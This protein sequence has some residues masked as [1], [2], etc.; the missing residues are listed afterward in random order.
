MKKIFT[1]IALILLVLLLI[2]GCTT[3]SETK[4]TFKNFA[5][6]KVFVNFRASLIQV[7]AGATVTVN[8]IPRGTYNYETTYEVPQGTSTATS[9]GAVSGE[10]TFDAGTEVLIVYSSTF[11][12]SVYTLYASLSSNVDLS[13]TGGGDPVG[14]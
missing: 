2:A 4:L 10:L 5:T 12:D 1:P 7:N 8:D 14:P 3:N 11:V 6:N 9:Q 13:S